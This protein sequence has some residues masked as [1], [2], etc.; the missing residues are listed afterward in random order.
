M[1]GRRRNPRSLALLGKVQI[2]ESLSLNSVGAA[3]SEGRCRSFLLFRTQRLPAEPLPA[4]PEPA[5][6][7]RPAPR[8]TGG[9]ARPDGRA[10][11]RMV[12]P[13]PPG[14]MTAGAMVCC[15]VTST[16][17][18]ALVAA[19]SVGW[20]STGGSVSRPGTGCTAGSSAWPRPATSCGVRSTG[21]GA[22]VNWSGTGAATPTAGTLFTDR[23]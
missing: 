9:G 18:P 7:D 8:W 23:P 5:R 14:T 17:G 4:G 19:T 3:Q 20:T 10:C 11:G 21:R 16:T 22:S 15:G 13:I 1:P 2:H 6:Q 12:L